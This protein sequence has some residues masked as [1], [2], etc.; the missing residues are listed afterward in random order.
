MFFRLRKYIIPNFNIEI[1]SII[2]VQLINFHIT[3]EPLSI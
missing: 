1:A 3:L 2:F